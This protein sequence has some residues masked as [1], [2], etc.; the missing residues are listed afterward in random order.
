M[1]SAAVKSA[2]TVEPAAAVEP[3]AVGPATAT[4]HLSVGGSD[5]AQN[6]ECRDTC[7]CKLLHPRLSHRRTSFT[8]PE[9]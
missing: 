2:A 6:R 9:K 7:D 8:P 5:T 4:V 3:T 1:E